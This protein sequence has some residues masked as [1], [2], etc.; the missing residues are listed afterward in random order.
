MLPARIPSLPWSVPVVRPGHPALEHERGHA[1][2]PLR[3]VD[4]GEDQEVVG[5]V[6]E[7]DPD[8][9]AVEPVGVAVAAR[10]RRPG[11]PRRCP[12]PG[13]VSPNVASFSPRA[14]GTSQRWRCSSV[15]PLE[16]G[17][18]VEP[19]VDALDDPERGVGTL[20]LL[21]QDGEADVVHPRRRR[22][23]PG[24]ARRGTPARPS[25]RTAR[26][27]PRPSRPTRGC[28]GR[29]SASA[30]ARDALL[31]EPVLVGQAE[32][33][34]RAAS[35][36]GQSAGRRRRARILGRPRPPGARP[37]M[38]DPTPSRRCRPRRAN[39]TPVLGRYFQRSWSHGEGHRLYDTDG[40]AYLDFA[41]GIAV[42]ALGHAHPRVTAAIHAQVDRLIGPI[43]ALGFT[44]P[45]ARL[46]DELAAT[47]PDPLDSVM[48]LNSGLGGDR[49]RAQARPPGHRPARDH[50]LPRRLPRPDVRR[51]ERD[52]LEPQLPDRLR[53]APARRLLRPVSRPPTPSSAATRPRRSSAALA[54]LRSLLATVIAPSQVARDPDRA[55]PGRGRLQPGAGR[56]PA[57]ACARSATSTGSCSSPTRSSRGYGRTGKMWAFEH[58]GIVPDVVCVAK[59]I[60]NGLP[61]SAI[62]SSRASSRSAGA[63]ART[64]R[65]TA[66]TRSPAPPAWPCSRRSA[67]RASSTNAAA[68]GAELRGRPRHDR[69]RGRPDRRRP[70]ARA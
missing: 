26:G 54:V 8:L 31:D 69:G 59:A 12:T 13:S 70:R 40:K 21:A 14:C 52:H 55:G 44:E 53:A 4:R 1:L 51:D 18:R 28:R 64:A 68:R 7:G 58:A 25:S 34:H 43:S 67:T 36:A 41:N 48:F 66:A 16:E 24:S 61:L 32:V 3:S 42:T 15:A 49:R 33:D 65:R 37:T 30:K 56:V 17:Q 62:V 39:L 27:G 22:T 10:G 45:I 29:I 63:A 23:P 46:A 57:A 6:G 2:V 60:A 20:Q 19:D 38:T 9:L 35:L 47:F 5:D 50:R 11:W